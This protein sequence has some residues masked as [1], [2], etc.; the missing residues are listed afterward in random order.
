MLGRNY[1]R[2]RSWR[3]SGCLGRTA[4]PEPLSRAWHH[5]CIKVA[6]QMNTTQGSTVHQAYPSSPSASLLD[7][8]EEGAGRHKALLIGLGVG[9]LALVGL[10]AWARSSRQARRRKAFWQT[11]S[12]LLAPGRAEPPPPPQQD[13]FVKHAL[14][15]AGTSL[16]ALTTQELGRRALR[17]WAP[18]E[19]TGPGQ[20]SQH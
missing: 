17:E 13:G 5:P 11:A 8:L 6:T 4:S 15:Q 9:A 16:L 1:T 10:V 19:P 14:K 20:A 18:P 2:G 12:Q 3:S 7:D